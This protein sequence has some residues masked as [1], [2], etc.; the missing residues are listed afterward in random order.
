M[1]MS[2]IALC[3]ALAL[4]LGNVALAHP[5]HTH[6]IMGTIAKVEARQLD[7]LDKAGETSTFA[8]TDKTKIWIG[9]KKGTVKDLKLAARV[10]VEG[11]EDED[12]KAEALVI[13]LGAQPAK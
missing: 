10:V 9:D 11:V 5:G 13:R 8:I 7:V 6:K 2:L 1:K 4:M 12:G 3:A